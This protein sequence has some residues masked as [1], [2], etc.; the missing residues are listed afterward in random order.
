MGDD[1]RAVLQV[2]SGT[3]NTGDVPQMGVGGLCMAE[4]VGGE[5]V[6]PAQGCGVRLWDSVG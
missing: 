2:S 1:G 3:P 6:G 5:V 4:R